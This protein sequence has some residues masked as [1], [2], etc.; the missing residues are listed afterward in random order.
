MLIHGWDFVNGERVPIAVL[1]DGTP[2]SLGAAA[3]GPNNVAAQKAILA[4]LRIIIAD[5]IGS[6]TT[7]QQDVIDGMAAAESAL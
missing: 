6:P 4:G 2:A 7:P 5:Q 3:F 1:P